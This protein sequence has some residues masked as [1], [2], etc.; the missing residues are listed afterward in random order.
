[1]RGCAP[2]APRA[3]ACPTRPRASAGCSR[4]EA[5]RAPRAHRRRRAAPR[6]A[7]LALA[8]PTPCYRCTTGARTNARMR[9]RLRARTRARRGASRSRRCPRATRRACLPGEAG[10]FAAQKARDRGCPA[11]TERLKPDGGW[12]TSWSVGATGARG[13]GRP[14]P[15]GNLLAL[16]ASAICMRR[17]RR[18]RT[19]GLRH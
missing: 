10:A 1:L 14:A 13:M 11:D 12:W 8:P 3:E 2:R 19:R 5:T 6:P 4:T 17:S 18:K 16:R 9:R 7:A 15:A